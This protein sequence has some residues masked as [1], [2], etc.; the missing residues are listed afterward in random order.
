MATQVVHIPSLNLLSHLFQITYLS[1]VSEDA[2]QHSQ[3]KVAGTL[4]P[5]TTPSIEEFCNALDVDLVMVTSNHAFHASD[6]GIALQ[7]NR[8]VFIE[9]LIALTVQD[10][11][12]ICCG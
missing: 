9:K 7:A 8:F 11:D 2:M 1:D 12:R 5:K 10:T 4:R 6:A 3:S